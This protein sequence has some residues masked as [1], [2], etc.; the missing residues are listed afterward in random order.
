LGTEEFLGGGAVEA[1]V[2]EAD[3]AGAI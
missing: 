2:D 1:V 3:F